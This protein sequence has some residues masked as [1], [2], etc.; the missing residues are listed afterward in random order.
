MK[1]GVGMSRRRRVGSVAAAAGVLLVIAGGVRADSPYG[2]TPGRPDVPGADRI[3]VRDA[4]LLDAAG[5]RLSLSDRVAASRAANSPVM[6]AVTQAADDAL[7]RAGMPAAAVAAKGPGSTGSGRGSSTGPFLDV[8]GDFDGDGRPD[9]LGRTLR[10][11]RGAQELD[12]VALKGVDGTPL[13][14]QHYAAASAWAFP[15]TVVGRAGVL[16][17]TTVVDESEAGV[18]SVSSPGVRGTSVDTSPAEAGTFTTTL[19]I[20]AIDGAGRRAWTASWT[21]VGS[22]GGDPT[23]A[24]A[25]RGASLPF[26][27]GVMDAGG[28]PD[29]DM[30][31][32][33]VD[34]NVA[35]RQRDACAT[36][37]SV[38]AAVAAGE[39]GGGRGLPLAGAASDEAEPELFA[40]PDLNGAGHGQLLFLTRER[41]G[42]RAEAFDAMAGTRLWRTDGLPAGG[43]PRLAAVGDTTG[44]GGTDVV[45]WST[46]SNYYRQLRPGTLLHGMDGRVLWTRPVAHPSRLAGMG[47]GGRDAVRSLFAEFDGSGGLQVVYEALSAQGLLARAAFAVPMDHP[48]EYLTIDLKDDLGDLDNDGVSDAGHRVV[49]V[50]DDDEQ[51]VRAQG[52]VSGRTLAKLWEGR[53]GRPVGR[54]AWGQDLADTRPAPGSLAVTRQDGATGRARWTTVVAGGREAGVAAADL[55]GDGVVDVVAPPAVLDGRTGATLWSIDGLA[56]PAA[57]RTEARRYAGAAGD[58]G[59]GTA[60]PGGVA[61]DCARAAVDVGVGGTCFALRGADRSMALRLDDAGGTAAADLQFTDDALPQPKVLGVVRVCGATAGSVPVPA[62]ARVAWVVVRSAPV[63]DCPGS[64]PSLHGTAT[65]RFT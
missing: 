1:L 4:K 29:T 62:G 30:L 24:W 22:Y 50:N 53:M 8:A 58:A 15:A 16:V 36:A 63:K 65:A 28:G 13:W 41:G 2:S 56:G 10:S 39:A 32:G 14:R 11:S 6:A 47:P 42:V 19:T 60:L 48:R 38:T 18:A 12:V 26:T 23:G 43:P 54:D 45:L 61:G 34:V 51:S 7:V 40:A 49:A 44:S 5:A 9:L 20:D 3:V 35:C 27:V 64:R 21:G 31:V 37:A 17:A 46:G 52:A 55:N 25:F 33:L 59:V 57:A